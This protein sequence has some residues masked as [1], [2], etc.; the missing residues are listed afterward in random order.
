VIPLNRVP[1][2]S[3]R[4]KGV[5]ARD[6]GVCWLCGYPGADTADHVVPRAHGGSDDP[7]NLRAA[8]RACNSARKDRAPSV[9]A[10]SRHW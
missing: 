2:W 3:E 10:P 8:H 9:P 4:S 7:S 1:H 6:R 5:I